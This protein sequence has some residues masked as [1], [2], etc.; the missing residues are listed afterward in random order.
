ME[1]AL[2]ILTLGTLVFAAHWFAEIFSKKRIP[3][4]L[5]LV[6]IGIIIGPLL[7]VVDADKL[8]SIGNVFGQLTLVTLLFESGTELSFRTLADS[9]KNTVTLTIVNFLITFIAIGALGWLALGMNPGIS[10]MLGAALGGSSSAVAIPLVKQIS[11][12]EKS[13]TILILESAFSAI[14]CIVVALA[15]FESYKYGEFRIGI[16][17]GQ[18]FSSFLL[19]SII[20]LLGSIFWSLVLDK[21]RTINNSIFTTPAFVFIIYGINEL[22]GYS[23]IISAL[24]FGIGLANMDLIHH[25]WLTKFT[26]RKPTLLNPMEKTLFSEL[27]FLMKTFFFVYVGISIKFDS[28]I[29]LLIGLGISVILIILRIPIVRISLPADINNVSNKDRAFL[30]MMIPRGLAA[31]VLATMISQS[32]LT[33]SEG[34]SNIVF[35]VIFFT[36]IFTS[37][38][39][40]FLEKSER[41]RRFYIKL[42]YFPSFGNNIIIF[43]DENTA[44][45]STESISN[46]SIFSNEEEERVSECDDDEDV[47]NILL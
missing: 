17:F 10:F 34:V 37:L 23:G 38:L 19:A 44:D 15:I 14:L 21:V 41:F 42:L 26:K 2:L 5:M 28:L 46:S 20:G 4:V 40:P 22:L 11:I 32:G 6:I 29:S 8:S 36:I 25:R 3:D 45:S 43:N 12:G 16:I 47:P 1:P 13:K 35:S 39:V 7:K 31:A 9:I 24:A 18:V 27:V 30:S 33:G